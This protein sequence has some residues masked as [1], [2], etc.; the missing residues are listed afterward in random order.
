MKAVIQAALEASIEAEDKLI[1]SMNSGML[2]YFCVER[3]DDESQLSSFL[4]RMAKMRIFKDENGKMNLDV[5]A[6]GGDIMLISQFTLAG[7][8]Y[9]GHRPGF[10]NAASPEEA[11]RIYQLALDYLEKAGY[12]VHCG[13]F[14]KH[15]KVRYI[16]DGPETFILDSQYIKKKN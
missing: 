12:K 14:G 13:A 11:R 1:S 7:D 6:A 5:N 9:H 10:D 4:D 8:V 2:V 3:E 16:N 15:M